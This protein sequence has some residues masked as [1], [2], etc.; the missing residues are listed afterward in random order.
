MLV[1]NLMTWFMLRQLQAYHHNMG[2]DHLHIHVINKKCKALRFIFIEI[3]SIDM[4]QNLMHFKQFSKCV[5]LMPKLMHIEIVF[6]YF[7]QSV[8]S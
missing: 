3:R 7:F 4:V 1:L 5:D 2:D 8:L 6:Q